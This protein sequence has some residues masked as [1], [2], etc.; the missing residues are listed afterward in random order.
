MEPII[1]ATKR[2][3][4]SSVHPIGKLL[5]P[6]FRNT[7]DINRN[8][9]QILINKIGIIP[10]DFTAGEY[11]M[12]ISSGAYKTWRFDMQALPKNLV[13]R[14]DQTHFQSILCSDH[15][16]L[17]ECCIVWFCFGFLRILDFV[18]HLNGTDAC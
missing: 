9:R 8:A 18:Y 16:L 17:V 2:T 4:L 5:E 14:C 7:F 1:I 12:K 3:L 13:E 10:N 6:T 11:S 15:Y